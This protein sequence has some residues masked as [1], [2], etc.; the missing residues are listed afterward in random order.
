M[1]T[2]SEIEEYYKAREQQLLEKLH[3]QEAASAAMP[4]GYPSCPRMRSML[5]LM[6]LLGLSGIVVYWKF[7]FGNYYFV[8]DDIGGDTS[9]QYI[10]QYYSIIIKHKIIISK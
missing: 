2:L 9:Q 10:W 4:D 8:F 1:N 7:L 6:A 3:Q 5:C